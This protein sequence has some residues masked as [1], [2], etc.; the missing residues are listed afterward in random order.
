MEKIKTSI[1]RRW[2][3]LDTLDRI[4]LLA[5]VVLHIFIIMTLWLN[6]AYFY[7]DNPTLINMAELP[8]FYAWFTPQPRF[9]P[10]TYM[11]SALAIRICGND[12]AYLFVANY[13][14]FVIGTVFLYLLAR[15]L[16][17]R[18]KQAVV[19]I[20]L[21]FVCSSSMENI[22]TIS[23]AEIPL[24]VAFAL[25]LLMLW[26]CL[27]EEKVSVLQ[28]ILYVFSVFL[29]SLSKETWFVIAVPLIV[30]VFYSV[31]FRLAFKVRA[32]VTAGIFLA[33]YLIMKLY[34]HFYVVSSA[35]MQM[36]SFSIPDMMKSF[37]GYAEANTDIFLIG[38]ITM[39]CALWL[40][41]K[42][43]SVRA[44]F[45]L[46]SN[47]TGWAYIS[48]LSVWQ[49]GATY[50]MFPVTF[51]FATSFAAVFFLDK[52]AWKRVIYAVV[53]VMGGYTSYLNYLVAVSH[54]D[55][56]EAYT[57]GCEAIAAYTQRGDRVLVENNYYFEEQAF[58]T[59]KLVARM[60]GDHDV[61]VL[62]GYQSIY[63]VYPGADT[64]QLW[65]TTEE[66][67]QT[68]CEKAKP[69]VGDYIFYMIN[70][71]NF[72]WNV[73]GVCPS[74]TELE[75][76]LADTY[77]L[78]ILDKF[79]EQKNVLNWK[80]NSLIPGRDTFYSGYILY[81][82]DKIGYQIKGVTADHW[83][84]GPLRIED[85]VLGDN[86]RIQFGPSFMYMVGEL[87]TNTVEIYVDGQ[88]KQTI[89]IQGAGGDILVID[90]VLS[91]T[92]SDGQMHSIELRIVETGSPSEYGM[93]D[94]RELGVQV[95]VI[96][97][98]NDITNN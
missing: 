66:D 40:V 44:G 57:R 51:W 11:I 79:I 46:A 7:I 83:T 6:M 52:L 17:L 12:P 56:G 3:E 77:E 34:A 80:D 76:A 31:V 18:A 8:V 61:D 13:L 78:E 26:N 5:L 10:I 9:I 25:F 54:V 19:V 91:D 1:T 32:F 68:Y 94:S 69:Q 82:V 75:S 4:L 16:G 38:I 30:L 59:D 97:G 58:N 21:L 81:R 84:E 35:Y 36:Y 65:G 60:R 42:E 95:T 33:V 43:R 87:T 55:L 29:C 93:Q 86:V 64:L 89:E 2:S 49:M 14:Y 15:K 90:D 24:I 62:G 98:Q 73:R 23:K 53:V 92:L 85:Y 63:G 41:W 50:Y 72:P 45:I 70:Q 28:W 20:L 37:L 48:G 27:T 88:F 47:L 96:N 39:L 22:F 67:Y 71:R 74:H